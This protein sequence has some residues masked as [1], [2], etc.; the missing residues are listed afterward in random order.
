MNCSIV[1]ACCT[2]IPR[3]LS[4][5]RRSFWGEIDRNEVCARTSIIGLPLLLFLFDEVA[6]I[7]TSRREFAQLVSDHVLGHIDRHMAA[8][9]VYRNR[10]SDHLREYGAGPTPGTDHNFFAFL[11]Q[12]LNFFEQLGADERPLFQ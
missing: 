7:G 3:T 6:A 5:T 4:M 11:V 1:T 8:A 9:I 12:L 2:F 10:V